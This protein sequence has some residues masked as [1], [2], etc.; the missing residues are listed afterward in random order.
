MELL[1]YLN[2]GH[3]SRGTTLVIT[4]SLVL[5][6]LVS[7]STFT[8]AFSSSAFPVSYVFL[9]FFLVFESF[10]HFR[11]LDEQEFFFLDVFSFSIVLF[12]FFFLSFFHLSVCLITVHGEDT[13][14]FCS[15]L[16]KK[17]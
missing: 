10:S 2:Q 5:S 12:F 15:F 4:L 16:K 11:F 8:H 14:V 7:F 1:G 17:N 13:G 3:P 6:T 9:F